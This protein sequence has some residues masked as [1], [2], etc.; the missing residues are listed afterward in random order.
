MIKRFFKSKLLRFFLVAGLNTAFGVAVYAF[1]VFIGFSYVWA[2]LLGMI[3]GIIFNFQTYG[4]IVFKNRDI[5]LIFRFVGVYGIMYL[6]NISGIWIFKRY[7][8]SEDT[9]WLHELNAL[10]PLITMEK[11]KDLLGG[12]FICIPNGLLGFI[13][14]RN[15][16]F[17]RKGKNT[18]K[19]KKENSHSKKL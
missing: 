15:F 5:R 7:I 8:I 1:L 12:L 14:N 2:S 16:V 3:I 11:L 19:D 18:D 10:L 9:L 13:L 17:N 4:G 6:F